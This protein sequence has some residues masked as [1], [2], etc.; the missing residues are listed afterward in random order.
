MR[1]A[2]ERKQWFLSKQKE[3]LQQLLVPRTETNHW[4]TS[5]GMYGKVKMPA[6]VTGKEVLRRDT[7]SQKKE[8]HIKYS[9]LSRAMY[10]KDEYKAKNFNPA[11]VLLIDTLAL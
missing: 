3:K 1:T 11:E 6:L 10:P 8:W 7:D 4:T 9:S 2:R 5:S